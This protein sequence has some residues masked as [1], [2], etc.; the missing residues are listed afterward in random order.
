MGALNF[1]HHKLVLGVYNHLIVIGVGYP[2]SLFFPKPVL[3]KRL[4]YSGW[5]EISKQTEQEFTA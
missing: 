2:A 3:D 1:T 4:L 5:R